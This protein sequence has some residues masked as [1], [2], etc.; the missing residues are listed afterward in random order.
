M[1]TLTL[2]NHAGGSGKS[3]LTRDIGYALAQAGQRV[4]LIDLDAQANLTDWLG[5][6]NVQAE[7]TIA[8]VAVRGEDLPEPVEVFGLH[9]IPADLG[10]AL[11]E[12]QM[13]GAVGAHLSLRQ[14]LQNVTDR[15]DIV[16]IDSPP[17][18]GQVAI[19]GAVAAD[20]MLVPV[21]TQQKGL[22]GL[23]GLTQA[24]AQYRRVRRDLT[25]ALYIP[26]KYDG[27][28]THDRETLAFLRESVSP[29]AQPIPDRGA[30][31]HEATAAGQPLGVYA[32]RS[33]AW[34]DVLKVTQE[35]ADAVGLNVQVNA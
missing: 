27:R 9:L 15:Y 10:L 18:L 11:I 28:R 25:V 21:L 7:Q 8:G 2:F 33:E 30:A 26:T 16:L 34:R 12:G 32:P 23:V 24:L 22:N 4:L 1:I 14:A 35:V 13:M 31:W 5:V 3:S 6:Q 19:L 20:A 29:V 17:S